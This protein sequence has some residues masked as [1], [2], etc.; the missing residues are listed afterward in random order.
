MNN[1]PLHQRTKLFN[2]LCQ[3]ENENCHFYDL[4]YDRDGMDATPYCIC[5]K[6][7][8]YNECDSSE[9]GMCVFQEDYERRLLK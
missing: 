5:K 4:G 8:H 9:I 1:P 3:A 7:E 2:C 6:C